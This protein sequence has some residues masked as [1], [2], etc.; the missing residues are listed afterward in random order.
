MMERIYV[1]RNTFLVAGIAAVL[2]FLALL[3]LGRNRDQVQTRDQES[4]SPEKRLALASALTQPATT[5]P[6][7][8]SLPVLD[9]WTPAPVEFVRLTT[10]FTLRNSRGKEVKQFEAGKRLRVSKRD[11]E[12]IT[13][14]Y[15]GTD[16]TIPAASTE[17]WK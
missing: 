9:R 4:S 14:N 5:Q 8:A 6:N 11:G 2:T 15:L 1:S 13:I 16:Y 10:E 12:T 17:P 3:W 7:P